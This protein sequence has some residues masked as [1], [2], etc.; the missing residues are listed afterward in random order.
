MSEKTEK[1]AEK[2]L[3]KNI[4]SRVDKGD[5]VEEERRVDRN[6]MEKVLTYSLK[7]PKTLESA[8]KL[9]GE[10]YCLTAFIATL[11]TDSDDAVERQGKPASEDKALR[12]AI[13]A[14]SP[15]K[16][17]RALAMLA[18]SAQAEAAKKK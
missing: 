7:I 4:L 16:K 15:E 5:H 8:K 18:E 9:Y 2:K 13:K 10:A 11:R 14:A 12:A 1:K 3:G 6:G 17:A